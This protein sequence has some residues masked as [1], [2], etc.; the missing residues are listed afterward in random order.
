MN[1]LN[2]TAATPEQQRVKDYLESNVSDVLADKINNGVRIEKDDKTLINK[3]DLSGFMA[4]AYEEARKLAKGANCACISADTVFGWAVHYFEEDS[5]EGT[6]YNEDGTV[7][8][9]S[10]PSPPKPK[11]KNTAP[12]AKKEDKKPVSKPK[13]EKSALPS[14]QFSLFDMLG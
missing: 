5:I 1:K 14:N 8:S 2:L 3:K 11:K 13:N 9:V 4:Y 12:E 7:H 10:K 6:L